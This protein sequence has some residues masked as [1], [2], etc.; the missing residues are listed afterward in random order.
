MSGR[1]CDIFTTQFYCLHPLPCFKYRY[2]LYVLYVLYVCNVG[3]A[4]YVLY[5]YG[6]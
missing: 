4:M 2:V 6:M 1:L 3:Y 5:V